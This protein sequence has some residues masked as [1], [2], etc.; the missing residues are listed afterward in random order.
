LGFTERSY[1]ER[2]FAQAVA[3]ACKTE[4]T[5]VEFSAADASELL[6]RAG[7]LLD[8]P[9]V[10]GSFLPIYRLSQV[11]RREVTGVLSGRGGDEP[12]CGYPQFPARKTARLMRRLSH[13]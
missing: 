12:F 4:H 7:D 1:D 13:T 2:P 3:R 8:E 5:E 11:A 10:D 9:L 6:E